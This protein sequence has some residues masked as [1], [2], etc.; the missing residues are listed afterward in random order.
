MPSNITLTERIQIKALC[1]QGFKAPYIAKYLNRHKTSIYRELSKKKPDG[2]YDYLYANNLSSS[3]MARY[4]YQG[5]DALIIDLIDKKIL[6]EQWSPEQISGWLKLH[7]DIS[8]SHT[9]IYQYIEQDRVQGGELANHLRIGKYTFG[10]REY[11]GKIPNRTTIDQRPEVINNRQRIGDYEIDLVVG[12]KNKGSILTAVDRSTR[13]C[14]IG[15]LR[16]K[17][18]E[19]VKEKTVD[20]FNKAA[21]LSITSDNGNEFICHQEIASQLDIK[22]YFANPYASYERGSIENLNGLIRQ[23]IPKGTPFD[24]ITDEFIAQIQHKLNNRPR[25]VLG[26]LTPLEFNDKMTHNK[27]TKLRLQV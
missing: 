6:N 14:K 10:A 4:R 17:E 19:V 12:P 9:W 18:A 25:K 3:N 26:F 5:P 22:Y 8:I 16:S 7:H 23:Y 21:I 11:K 1:D 24:E 27:A 13:I 2:N 15:K 20:I